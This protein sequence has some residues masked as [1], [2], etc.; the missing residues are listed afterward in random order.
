MGITSCGRGWGIK[1]IEYTRDGSASVK[2]PSIFFLS[3]LV[4]PD[5][6]YISVFIPL[7]KNEIDKLVRPLNKSNDS[8]KRKI[9]SLT[10]VIRYSQPSTITKSLKDTQIQLELANSLANPIRDALKNG[11]HIYIE[12]RDSNIEYLTILVSGLLS[13]V[14]LC[15]VILIVRKRTK[16]HLVHVL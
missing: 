3:T 15:K 10:R 12:P 16:Q 8:M 6:V 4:H 5:T 14:V 11:S 13:L 7:S 1:R 9:D 2:A